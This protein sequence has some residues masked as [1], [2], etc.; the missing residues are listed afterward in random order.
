[1]SDQKLSLHFWLSEFT[2]SQTAERLGFDNTPSAQAVNNLQS[3]VSYV[4]QPLRRYYNCPIVISSGYRCLQLNRAIGSKNTSQHLTGEAADFTIPSI[5]NL[6]VAQWI[7][8]NLPFDQ[9]ILEFWTGGNT[10]WIHCSYSLTRMRK[11]VLTI[12][13][14]GTHTGFKL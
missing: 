11:N 5:E 14:K 3:L 4:L 13:D 6:E 7:K 8:K 9:L 1:M 10:G 12:N 2:R